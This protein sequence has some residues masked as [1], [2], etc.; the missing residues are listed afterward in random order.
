MLILFAVQVFFLES[1]SSSSSQTSDTG[2]PSGS[3]SSQTSNSGSSSSQSSISDSSSN[4]LQATPFPSWTPTAT[5]LPPKTPK[6]SLLP[7]YAPQ[8]TPFPLQNTYCIIFNGNT[9]CPYGSIPIEP[10]NFNSTIISSTSIVAYVSGI[11]SCN[12]TISGVNVS[13]QLIGLSNTFNLSIQVT[14]DIRFLSI[15][16]MGCNFIGSPIK[17]FP[18][19]E[20]LN[21][22]LDMSTISATYIKSDFQSLNSMNTTYVNSILEIQ[23]DLPLVTSTPSLSFSNSSKVVIPSNYYNVKTGPNFVSLM[24]NAIENTLIGCKYFVFRRTRTLNI[25]GTTVEKTIKSGTTIP[26]LDLDMASGSTLAISGTIPSVSGV[27]PI[28][29]SSFSGNC[30]LVLNTV[31]PIEF[32]SKSKISISFDT[33]GYVD[34]SMISDTNLSILTEN[35]KIKNVEIGSYAL[36]MK[37]GTHVVTLTYGSSLTGS[38]TV[39]NSN[40]DTALKV[41]VLKEYNGYTPSTIL[42]FSIELEDRSKTELL[43]GWNSYTGSQKLK[44]VTPTTN[45]QVTSAGSFPSGVSVYSDKGDPINPDSLAITHFEPNQPTSPLGAVIGGIIA[46]AAIAIFLKNFK[47]N[48]VEGDQIDE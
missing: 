2:S 20:L 47:S 17:N 30:K 5:A 40:K 37:N 24:N 1:S 10:H 12:L 25:I 42:P 31:A 22:N 14:N 43:S 35:G 15:K 34:T 39:V 6:A 36:V 38:F 3:S 32:R 44:I 48:Q 27:F 41:D 26:Y 18:H 19:I 46:I 16:N 33:A 8:P 9:S 11:G 13:L 28:L 45:V 29:L 23:G 4:I 21:C 7:T